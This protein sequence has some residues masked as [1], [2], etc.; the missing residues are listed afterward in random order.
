MGNNRPIKVKCWERFLESKGCAFKSQV[1]TSHHKWRCPGCI[2]SI[3]FR[4]AEKE[5]P[6]AHISTSLSSMGVSKEDFHKWINENC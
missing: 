4:G 5:I 3:V 2:M 1:K 6:F